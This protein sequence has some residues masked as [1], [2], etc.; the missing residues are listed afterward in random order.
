MHSARKLGWLMAVIVIGC[1][2]DKDS[3]DASTDSSLGDGSSGT[4]GSSGG[5]SGGSSGGGGVAAT[6]GGGGAGD[7]D[8][9][10]GAATDGGAGTGG[11]SGTGGTG[12]AGGSA[13]TG[14]TGGGAC[15]PVMCQNQVYACAD[16]LDNDNDGKID[17]NDPD[18]LGPCHNAEDTFYGS[19]PG[20]AG[21]DCKTDCYFDNDSGSGNDDCYWDHGCDMLEPEACN[22]DPNTNTSG[23]P[24]TCSQLNA[25]QSNTCEQVCAPLTPNGC[26]CFGCCELPAGQGSYV[27]LGSLDD[28]GQP[29]CSLGNETDPE[30]CEPCTPVDACLNT[31]E[32]CELC[33]G[34]TELPEDC[35]PT[36]GMG[37]DGGTGGTGGTGGM[38][39]TG[40]TGGT[41]GSSG[42]GGTGGT[43]GMG[44]S[45]GT[46]GTGGSC[47]SPLCAPGVQPCG[48]SCLPT[49]GPG[50]FCI[51]G[52]CLDFG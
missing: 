4:G 40:G 43:G 44:G 26:D 47:P 33:L 51:T 12:G 13:G 32:H 35:Q 5:G 25:Q 9:G 29:S 27:W 46:G 2:A 31:C 23:T 11:S 1:A 48:V 15:V 52:C 17:A 20:Q 38:S 14:G 49:C 21:A 19:I 28:N 16:C 42:T 30:K 6:D 37:G 22:Y 45:S 10:G 34:K 24:L 39:G 7:M 50:T 36:G 8:G 41:G 3:G 18:C